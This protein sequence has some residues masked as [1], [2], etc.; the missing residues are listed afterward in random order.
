MTTAGDPNQIWH[1]DYE[2]KDAFERWLK[3]GVS[4]GGWTDEMVEDMRLA[5]NAA[6][7]ECAKIA[8][9]ATDRGENLDEAQ[10]AIKMV[11]SEIEKAIRAR[12]EATEVGQDMP[13]G[14]GDAMAASIRSMIEG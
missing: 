4:P 8:N 13:S 12:G 6:V 9:A 11:A 2:P 3:T 10:V 1:T 5:W 14:T 7:E